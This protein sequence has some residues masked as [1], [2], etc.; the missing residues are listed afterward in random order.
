MKKILIIKAS[1]RKDGNSDLLSKEFER[2]ALDAGHSVKSV[3]LKDKNIK[4]CMACYGCRKEGLCVIKDD[5]KEILD[6]MLSS[7]V[8]VL[9][10]PVYFYSMAGSLKT[11]I[12]RTL[13]VYTKLINKEFYFIITAAAEKEMLK[14]TEDALLGFTDCLPDAKVVDVI[15]GDNVYLKGEVKETDAYK[16]AYE[17][18]RRV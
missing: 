17:D 16:K 13:P 4:N 2:G 9:A 15:F 3:Y 6:D 12:D 11:L 18:G 10:T 1:P 8:I 7:D 5:A 14:R